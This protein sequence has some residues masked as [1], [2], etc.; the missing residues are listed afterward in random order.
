MKS[1]TTELDGGFIQDVYRTSS[2]TYAVVALCVF[3]YLGAP[4]L[5][6]LTAGVA[7]ALGSLR[8]I[9]WSVHRF[10]A[11]VRGEVPAPRA[12][13]R[14]LLWLVGAGK[15]LLLALAIAGVVRAAE[16]GYLNLLAF[17]GGILLVHAVIV[18]QAIGAWLFPDPR[19]GESRTRLSK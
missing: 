10:T 5:L 19:R 14:S 16:A 12:V 18:L 1:A 6:G 17:V 7:L 15:Y 13:A 4:A 11:V 2:W 3:S 8:L 9:E